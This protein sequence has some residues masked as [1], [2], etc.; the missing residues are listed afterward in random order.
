MQAKTHG[1]VIIL[2][3]IIPCCMHHSVQHAI[4]SSPMGR[5]HLVS[6]NSI[7]FIDS[8]FLQYAV[9]IGKVVK[10]PV[11]LLSQTFFFTIS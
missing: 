5:I 8:F 4:L 6:I 9:Y 7:S 1:Y 10:R 11:A 2:I 3:G